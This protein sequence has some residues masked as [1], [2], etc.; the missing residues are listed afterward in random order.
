M[1][2]AA[3]SEQAY[4]CSRGGPHYGFDPLVLH[5]SSD[6]QPLV[7]HLAVKAGSNHSNRTPMWSV[8]LRKMVMYQR[9]IDW[10]IY[11]VFPWRIA[12]RSSWIARTQVDNNKLRMIVRVLCTESDQ[13]SDQI[14]SEFSAQSADWNTDQVQSKL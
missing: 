3:E 5:L 4:T 6:V 14:Q 11:I 1:W 8:T 13:T 7:R 12:A 9:G 10:K 2:R